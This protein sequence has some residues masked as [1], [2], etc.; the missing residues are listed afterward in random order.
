MHT[1]IVC[2]IGAKRYNGKGTFLSEGTDGFVKS[3][4]RQTFYFLELENLNLGDF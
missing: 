2:K 1:G 4:S 3:P